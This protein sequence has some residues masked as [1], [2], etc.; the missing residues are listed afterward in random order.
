M[1]EWRTI[2]FGFPAMYVGLICCCL[3]QRR[4]CQR[5]LGRALSARGAWGLRFTGIP[6]L[7]LPWM[8][9]AAESGPLAAT[10]WWCGLATVAALVLIA[11]LAYAPRV[12]L[13]ISAL[14]A[15]SMLGQLAGGEIG[16]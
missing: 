16:F 7:S 5:A 11:S 10:A 2:M 12:A 13:G 8:A 9:I 14:S 15:L 3:S 6:F 4:Q 1:N